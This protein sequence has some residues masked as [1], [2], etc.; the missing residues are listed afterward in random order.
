MNK[1]KIL[2]LA[3]GATFFSC[4]NDN[5]GSKASD[6]KMTNK[7]IP[8]EIVQTLKDTYVN[9][10]DLKIVDFLLP[11]GTTQKMYQV[12]GDIHMTEEHIAQRKKNALSSKNY[13]THNLVKSGTVINI[14]GYTG[15]NQALSRKEQ[16]AL[17]GA[18]ENY[19]RLNLDISFRLSFGTNHRASDMVVYH[20]PKNSSAGGS[21]GFPTGGRPHKYVQIHGLNRYSTNIV[22]HVITHEIGHSIGFRHTDWYSRQSCGQN[23]NE[24]TAGVGANG[25]PGTTEGYDPTSLMLA[26]FNN[27][28]RGDF[29][30]NDLTALRYLY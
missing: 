25:I 10:D 15:G 11:D 6:E 28:S 1:T 24:G 13:H 9:T 4:Q 16:R 23:S 30:R 7:D 17:R 3:V 12:E 5:N 19:N 18:V 20:N 21:A 14:L 2:L 29:N 26:C 8:Q 27:N 22:K